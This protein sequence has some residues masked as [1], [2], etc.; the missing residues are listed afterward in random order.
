M[1]KPTNDQVTERGRRLCERQQRREAFQQAA[2]EIRQDRSFPRVLRRVAKHALR[3]QSQPFSDQGSS[4]TSLW[5]AESIMQTLAD[6]DRDAEAFAALESDSDGEESVQSNYKCSHDAPDGQ[7]EEESDD[8][9]T[10]EPTEELPFVPGD[11]QSP[12]KTECAITPPADEAEDHT[13]TPPV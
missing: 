13:P 7:E 12:I 6:G 9:S 10:L 4:L 1:S 8:T 3:F 11:R 5:E 2:E